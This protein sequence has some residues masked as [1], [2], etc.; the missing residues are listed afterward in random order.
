[1]A[2]L[3][4][5]DG[6]VA[7]ITINRPEAMNA[8]DRQ[9]AEELAEAWER[10]RTDAD[11]WVAI[12]TG[13]GD[14]AFCAGA[15]TKSPLDP[16]QLEEVPGGVKTRITFDLK[17]LN[18][19]KP[20]IAAVNGFAL[21]GGFEIVLACDI[22]IA[23]EKAT[24]GL[25]EPRVGL[26]AAAG[27]V[28]RLPRRIP[29]HIAMG[30]M[31]TGRHMSARR[32]YEL[33]LVNDVVPYD[34]LDETVQGYV[35]DILACAPLSVRAT[36]EMVMRGLDYPLHEAFD[37]EYQWEKRRQSSPDAIEGPRAFAEKRK[38][39]WTGEFVED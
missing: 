29:Y 39:N 36:K 32:A 11:I 18:V 2:L 27:G 4:Q 26:M 21:G 34:K 28:H 12:L 10:V 5:L 20:I 23:S 17:G 16:S 25:P 1:M 33:G 7:T 6:H 30:Y 3:F 13:A 15:D 38:P 14:R 19:W 8:I 35:K 9:T 37:R 22:I 24:F 31:L